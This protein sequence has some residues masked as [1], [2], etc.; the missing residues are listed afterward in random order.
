[1]TM[2]TEEILQL[3]ADSIRGTDEDH[4]RGPVRRSIALLAIPMMLEMLMEAIF[5]VTDIFFVARLGSAAVAAVGMTEAVLTLVYAV[6]IGLSAATTA[7]VARRIGEGDSRGASVAA[8]Q[9]LWIGALVSALMGIAGIILGEQ[10]LTW[11]GADQE[12]VVGGSIY[13]KILLGGSASIT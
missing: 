4:T 9:A 1:M 11:L 7:M 13:T 3:F 8:A 6:A 5:A 2:R 12:V 10:I